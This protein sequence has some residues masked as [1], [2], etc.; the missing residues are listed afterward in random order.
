MANWSVHGNVFV[1]G[2]E[3]GHWRVS[4]PQVT[5]KW[6]ET[7]RTEPR[8]FSSSLSAEDSSSSG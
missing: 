5:D 7:H 4:V 8:E 3:K 6:G 2:P 1:S